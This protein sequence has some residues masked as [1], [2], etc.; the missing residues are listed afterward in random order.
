MAAEKNEDYSSTLL[1]YQP[2]KGWSPIDYNNTPDLDVPTVR[3]A[4]L[5][6]TAPP[7]PVIQKKVVSMNGTALSNKP[8]EAPAAASAST[9][10]TTNAEHVP[11]SDLEDYLAS[12]AKDHDQFGLHALEVADLETLGERLPEIF[13][14]VDAYAQEASQLSWGDIAQSIQALQHSREERAHYVQLLETLDQRIAA[15]TETLKTDL[16]HIEKQER[17]KTAAAR[18]KERLSLH[19]AQVLSK[20]I[21]TLLE[22]KP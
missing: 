6:S 20:R 15:L 21:Q 13:Q 11:F 19:T 2:G 5:E 1:R 9:S 17:A 12:Q 3:A 22:P 10:T 16:K 4:A 8:A 7:A 14:A 18:L